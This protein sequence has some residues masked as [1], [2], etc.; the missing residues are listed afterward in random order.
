MIVD[1]E[2]S[3]MWLLYDAGPRNIRCS[4]ISLPPMNGIADVFFH[5][6]L[7]LTVW[8]YQVKALQYPVYWDHLEFCDGFIKLSDR[9]NWI[10]CIFW[11]LLREA[12]WPKKFAECTHKFP[13]VHSLILCDSFSDTSIFNQT[14]TT[15]RIG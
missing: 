1:D 4:L 2:D 10:K 14:W 8:G 15:N 6:T 5:Q 13:R 7:A 9:Y 12:F 11:G 3:K